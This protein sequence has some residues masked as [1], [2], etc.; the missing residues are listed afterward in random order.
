MDNLQDKIQN[1]LQNSFTYEEYM[2]QVTNLVANKK[3]SGEIQSDLLTNYTKLNYARMKRLNKTQRIDDLTLKTLKLLNQNYTWILLTETWCGDA[4]QT[5]P[6]IHKIANSSKNI[7]L[8]VAY[9]DENMELMDHFL[10]NGGAAIPKL[11]MINNKNEVLA[12]WGPRPSSATIM[13]DNYKSKHG[14]LTPE[15]KEE[16][17]NWY[18]KNKGADTLNDLNV[19]L[20]NVLIKNEN[21]ILEK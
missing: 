7:D 1:A 10:T 11:I 8:R 9:R 19:L 14:S 6:F 12:D 16:L 13:V 21:L 5:I 3:S 18:N 17:Q 4:A 2:E 15:F 20:L